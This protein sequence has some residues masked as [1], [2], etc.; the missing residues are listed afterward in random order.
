M[1]EEIVARILRLPGYGIAEWAL[2]EG[3]RALTLSIRQTAEEPYYV[4]GGCGI[5][6]REIHNWTERRLGDL[7]WGT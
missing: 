1:P 6:V 4:C 7:P 3:A 5:S 2:D